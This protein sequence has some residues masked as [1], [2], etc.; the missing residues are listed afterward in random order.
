MTVDRFPLQWPVGRRRTPANQRKTGR[1][2]QQAEGHNYRRMVPVTIATALKRLD[3]EIERIG[4]KLPVLSSNLDLRLDGRPRSGQREPDDPGVALYYQ[5]NGRPYCLPCDTYHGAADNIAAIAAH[6]EATRAIERYGVA[7]VA[8]MFAGFAALPAPATKRPWW[9]VLNV[10]PV[11]SVDDI[12]AAHRKAAMRHHENGSHPDPLKMTEIN[13]AR[14]EG[15][16]ERG[17]L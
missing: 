9:E 10:H 16:R 1:F 7:T 17:A 11:A 6:I 4:A 13:V 12:R 2:T 15:L 5:L 14:D 8:E 3:N